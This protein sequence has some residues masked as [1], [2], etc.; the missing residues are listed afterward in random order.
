VSFL[1]RIRTCQVFSPDDYLPFRVDGGR[2]GWVRPAMA[3]ALRK[4]ADVFAVSA[5]AVDLAPDIAGFAARSSAVAAVIRSLIDEAVLDGW[6]G[7]A[8]AVG[9]RFAAPLFTI[10]RGAVPPF[11]VRGYGVHLNGYVRRGGELSMWIGRRSPTKR[12]APNKLDQ[13]VAGGQPASLTP[14]EN[15]VKEAAEEASIPRALALKAIPVGAITYCTEREDGLRNDV[16]F[17]YDLEVPED[18][19]PRNTDGELTGFEL[20]PLAEVMELVRT[21]DAFKFNC[22]LVVIDFLIRHGLIAPEH[23]EY[24][25]LVAGLRSGQA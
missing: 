14:R 16:L 13:L 15:L 19:T 9:P 18:F 8:Y 7:E 25:D 2:V 20:L 22:A 10:D 5:D 24:L 17:V 4:H 12:T 11:G 21:T 3:E 23:P 6:R 1:D